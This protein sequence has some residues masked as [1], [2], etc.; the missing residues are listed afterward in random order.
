MSFRHSAKHWRK[1]WRRRK[2]GDPL[3]QFIGGIIINHS[4]I[5][6]LSTRDFGGSGGGNMQQ[7]FSDHCCSIKNETNCGIDMIKN[8]N[9]YWAGV[10]RNFLPL[11]KAQDIVLALM[12][13]DF[14]GRTQKHLRQD[15]FKCQFCSH[16]NITKSFE[17]KNRN[18]GN[19]LWVGCECIHKFYRDV[20]MPSKTDID[21]ESEIEKKQAEYID[22]LRRK[23]RRQVTKVLMKEF[24]DVFSQAFMESRSDGYS[25]WDIYLFK[26][27]AKQIDLPMDVSD[28]SNT[29]RFEE[30]LKKLMSMPKWLFDEIREAL[31]IKWQKILD[32]KFRKE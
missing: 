3:S 4:A 9:N 27:Y 19:V 17:T 5:P 26:S 8:N 11:S 1:P 14:T 2:G 16:P 23:N 20:I 28:F 6:P 24:P 31:P 13:W 21:I 15:A 18:N 29:L 7:S 25:V 22:D 10:S 12:E 32:N 30:D